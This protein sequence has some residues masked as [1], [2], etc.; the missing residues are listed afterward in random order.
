MVS[1][2]FY[3]PKGEEK[4][5]YTQ[6]YSQDTTLSTAF[7]KGTKMFDTSMAGVM[8]EDTIKTERFSFKKPKWKDKSDFLSELSKRIEKSFKEIFGVKS[9]PKGVANDITQ[10]IRW[11][12]NITSSDIM[13]SIGDNAERD[14]NFWVN[15]TFYQNFNQENNLMKHQRKNMTNIY[16]NVSGTIK[17]AAKDFEDYFDMEM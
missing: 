5:D 4:M 11:V 3:R 13:K 16:D 1:S 12:N 14:F 6:F 15:D 2:F 17:N 9:T 10:K 8:G 7:E